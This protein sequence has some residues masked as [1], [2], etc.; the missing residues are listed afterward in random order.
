M[1][2][3]AGGNGPGMVRR[4]LTPM[5]AVV[6]VGAGAL[7]LSPPAGAAATGATKAE[8]RTALRAFYAAAL[9]DRRPRA[10]CRHATRGFRLV[11]DPIAGGNVAARRARAAERCVALVRAVID[12]RAGAFPWAAFAIDELRLTHGGRRARAVTSDGSAWLRR[13]GGRWRVH[14]ITA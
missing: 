4:A 2:R 5:L 10:A 9:R 6:T 13:S 3:A 11:G 7:A 1:P 14:A 12:R 8:A